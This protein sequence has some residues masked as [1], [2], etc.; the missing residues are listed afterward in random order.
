MGRAEPCPVH[1]SLEESHEI[2]KQP[3][4]KLVEPLKAQAVEDRLLE[5]SLEV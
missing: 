3:L 1:K 4:G 5:P 2:K